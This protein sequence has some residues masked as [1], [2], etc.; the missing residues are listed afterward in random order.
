[1]PH[2]IYALIDPRKPQEI[3]YVGITSSLTKRF[4]S[5]V[6]PILAKE[7]WIRQLQLQRIEP[8]YFVIEMVDKHDEALKR[9]KFHIDKN[10]G[11]LL[12]NGKTADINGL[13]P[14]GVEPLH[15]RERKLLEHAMEACRG[16]K[17]DMAKR[18]GITRPTLYDKLNKYGLIKHV[19][20]AILNKSTST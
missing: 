8:S 2:Y 7:A 13:E 1:M 3:R 15:V 17:S 18:L 10:A 19:K 4:H 11:P 16:N 5:H 12:L 9:E 20:P 14:I 6:R